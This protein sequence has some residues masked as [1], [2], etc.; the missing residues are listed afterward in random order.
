MIRGKDVNPGKVAIVD[1]DHNARLSQ[2][3]IGD[4]QICV[5]DGNAIDLKGLNGTLGTYIRKACII[6]RGNATDALIHRNDPEVG[7][8]WH[9]SRIRE[10]HPEAHTS[11]FGKK[12]KPGLNTGLLY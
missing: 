12:K 10:D 2:F 8:H 3:C 9:T 1:L 6:I 7:S 11:A 5:T 4:Q